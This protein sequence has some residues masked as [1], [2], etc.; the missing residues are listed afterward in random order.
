MN[1]YWENQMLAWMS[2][3]D[4]P[5]DVEGWLSDEEQDIQVKPI[6]LRVRNTATG[7]SYID[8]EQYLPTKPTYK[9]LRVRNTATDTSYT[10]D[11]ER[12]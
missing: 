11:I 3:I 2:G 12:S 6:L 1:Q 9:L 10:D 8:E 5:P 4:H 7:P